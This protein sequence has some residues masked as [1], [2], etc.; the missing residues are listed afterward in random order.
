MKKSQ[1]RLEAI[2]AGLTTYTPESPCVKGHSLR[3]ISGTCI[4]CRRL[5]EKTQYY[6]N[7]EQ[8]KQRVKEKYQRHAEVLKAKRRAAYAENPE[9]EKISAKIRSAEWRKAN[10]AHVGNKIAKTKWKRNNIGKVRADTVKRRAAKLQRTPAWLTVDDLWMLEQ[11]YE[12]AALRTKM[13]GFSWHVD[14]II[15]LQGKLVSGLHVPTNVRV[16]P[17]VENVRK[18]NRYVP[19]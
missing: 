14:H 1:A 11:A 7:P 3:S 17:G 8:T 19:A 18:A 6:A 10:P 16:I 12:L 5:R 13:F 4:E 9:K 15:P 2:A